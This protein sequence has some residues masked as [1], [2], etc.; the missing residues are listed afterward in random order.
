MDEWKLEATGGNFACVI[1][2]HDL[3]LDRVHF[4]SLHLALSLATVRVTRF[5]TVAPYSSGFAGSART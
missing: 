4:R 1:Q 3:K 5:H 2:M